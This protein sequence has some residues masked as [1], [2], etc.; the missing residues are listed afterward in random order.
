MARLREPP[1]A[2]SQPRSALLDEA[3]RVY[4]GDFAPNV[5]PVAAVRA[6][7]LAASGRR[8]RGAEPGRA[9]GALDGRRR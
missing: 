7:V 2:T 5:R 3:E 9:T 8:G 1:R 6:R 4:V